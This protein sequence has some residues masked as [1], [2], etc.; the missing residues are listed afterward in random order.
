MRGRWPE[1]EWRASS[2]SQLLLSGNGSR[3]CAGVTAK[4]ELRDIQWLEGV[5]LI[6]SLDRSDQSLGPKAAVQHWML[7]SPGQKPGWGMPWNSSHSPASKQS[8]IS[9]L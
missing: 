8:P 6:A 1:S 5:G 7:F 2:P 3:S 9:P 4:C